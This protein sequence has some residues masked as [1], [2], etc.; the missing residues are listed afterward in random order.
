MLKLEK[1]HIITALLKAKLTYLE[2]DYV[3]DKECQ[4]LSQIIMQEF[5]NKGY[6]VLIVDKIDT[7]Y[8]AI[9]KP[10][11][12]L[13]KGYYL[14]NLEQDLPSLDPIFHNILGNEK[15][16]FDL[17][18]NPIAIAE[19]K[20]KE[21]NGTNLEVL[22]EKVLKTPKHFYELIAKTLSKEEYQYLMSLLDMPHTCQNCTSKCITNLPEA[23]ATNCP[24]WSN[25]EAVGKL[26]VLS[27]KV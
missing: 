20:L 26:K 18:Y 5:M 3:T 23:E 10:L 1:N 2:E 4:E 6:N 12:I 25:H 16:V 17:I 8:F 13:K 21:V 24:N 19:R 7:K 22:L 15:R 9:H 27:K 11:I 14:C